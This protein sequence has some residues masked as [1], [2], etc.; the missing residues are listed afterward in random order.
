VITL[1]PDKNLKSADWT[2]KSWDLPPY[3]SD[4]FLEVLLSQGITLETFKKLPVYKEAVRAGLIKKDK[5]IGPTDGWRST[6]TG[7]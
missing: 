1:R 3:K 7:K 5:W 2:K 6:I 4:E